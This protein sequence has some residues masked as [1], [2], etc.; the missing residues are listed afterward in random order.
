MYFCDSHTHTL[1]SPDSHAPLADMAQ[2]A[3]ALG[4]DEL[5]VTDHCD[6][7][8]FRGQPV[9]SFDWPAA[10]AQYHAVRDGLGGRLTLRLGLEL[11][12]AVCDPPAARR[13]L[14]EGGDELDFV[15]GSLHNWIGTEGCGDL[16]FS[17]FHNDPALARKAVDNCLTHTWDLVQSCPD[18]YDSLAHVIYPLRYIRRD[19]LE[20][21]LLDGWEEQLRAIFT[22]VARTDHAL[23]VNTCRGRDLDEWLPLL[24]LFRACG[25]RLIT[26]G[27]DA[28]RP[29]DLAL[30]I[31]RAA[32]LLQAAG[33]AHVTTFHQRK[34]I[35][36]RL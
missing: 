21:S 7:L 16:Y 34:P 5:C 14:A 24:R 12:S 32:E 17:D 4:L 30:G 10:K 29:E 18:C 13:I 19:G 33:F 25:G 1:I 31:P 2:R 28:H 35:L 15:L 6:L 26:L 3:L 9:S 20:L 36:H 11:G 27:S 22:Q 8:N 23:E